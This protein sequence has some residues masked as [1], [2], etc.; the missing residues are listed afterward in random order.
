MVSVSISP[1]FPALISIGA[2]SPSFL[3]L[4]TTPQ[5]VS[6]SDR[7]AFLPVPIHQ[8]QPDIRIN[9]TYTPYPLIPVDMPRSRSC[10][11]AA[12]ARVKNTAQRGGH[13]MKTRF[14]S[15]RGPRASISTRS[16]SIVSSALHFTR[17]LCGSALVASDDESPKGP[18]TN[19]RREELTLGTDVEGWVFHISSYQN[20]HSLYDSR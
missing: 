7:L 12:M 17:N 5:V 3:S 9:H 16:L 2:S 18:P 20:H 13:W 15:F 4:L 11:I 14:G 6:E 19:F 1:L 8:S 10:A